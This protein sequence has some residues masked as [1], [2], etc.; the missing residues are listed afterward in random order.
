LLTALAPNC[1]PP[2]LDLDV[3]S[4]TGET[5]SPP[6]SYAWREWPLTA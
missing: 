2:A 3:I 1:K 6:A 5:R 4:R